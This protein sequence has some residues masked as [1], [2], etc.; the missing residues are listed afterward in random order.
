M[1]QSKD[2]IVRDYLANI[3]RRGGKKSTRKLDAETAREMVRIREARRAYKLFYHECF[4]S[5]DPS[6]MITKDDV[7]WV[8]EQL[9]KNG[10][11]KC[12][13]VGRRL[14]Q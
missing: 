7:Q 14:C 12:W 9:M 5:F 13:K 2:Q 8:A 4:W 6:L 10:S 3:G 11:I 1:R